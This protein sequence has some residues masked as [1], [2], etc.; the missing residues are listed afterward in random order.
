LVAGSRTPVGTGDRDVHG[1][2]AA[3]DNE[4]PYLPMPV[5]KSELSGANCTATAAASI[6]TPL[7]LMV[8]V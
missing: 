1:D 6:R 5:R 2:V 4:V 8:D 3:V 7:T